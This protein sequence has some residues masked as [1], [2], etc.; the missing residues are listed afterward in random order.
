[1]A[2]AKDA[3]A[4]AFGHMTGL[5]TS[6]LTVFDD[7]LGLD[8]ESLRVNVEYLLTNVGAD[9]LGYGHSD[10]W[11]LTAAERKETAAAF[12]TAVAGRVPAYVH[13]TDHSAP[14]TVDLARHAAA[15]GADFVMI[16][17]PY[18]W[19][20]TDAHII[21]YF[22]YVTDHT[23][24]AILLLNTPHSGRI[25]SPELMNR[26]ADLPAICGLKNGIRDV[27]QTRRIVELAGDRMVISHPREEEALICI[28]ELGQQVQLGT[29]AVFLLQQQD[30]QPIREY[31]ELAK[32]GE[33]A[34]ARQVYDS[35]APSRDVWTSMY[36][37]LWTDGPEHPIAATKLWMEEMGMRGGPVR[38]PMREVDPAAG[39]ELRQRIRAGLAEA[40]RRYSEVSVSGASR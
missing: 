7:A 31:V 19:A 5:W 29:S 6:P 33:G 17:P 36:L 8:H 15:N 14:V 35:M 40:R 32:R 38:P 11:T 20:K 27:E 12:L 22:T 26:L 1:M 24:I 9:G 18:E 39:E 4:Y 21:D 13:A 25:M 3:K 37:T 23:D 2:T 34:R 16:H 10:S 30:Y 28:E